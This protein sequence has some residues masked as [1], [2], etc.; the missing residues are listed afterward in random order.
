MNF[1]ISQPLN[2]RG[3]VSIGMLR[4]DGVACT[5]TGPVTQW[6]K[7]YKMLNAAYTC[8]NGRNTTA[9]V[10]EL[11]ATTFGIEGRWSAFVEDSCVETG[12]FN[13]VKR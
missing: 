9:N 6:G 8:T 5:V 4:A 2:N 1:S 7:F 13:A 11:G 3:P 12:V 10:N